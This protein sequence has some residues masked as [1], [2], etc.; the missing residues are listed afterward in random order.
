MSDLL[1][2]NA[3]FIDREIE[4]FRKVLDHRFKLHAQSHAVFEFEEIRPPR[5]PAKHV[6]YTDVVRAY[7]LTSAERL[8]L[9]LAYLPH[10]RPEEL[11]AFLVQNEAVNRRFT[12]FGGVVGTNHGGFLPTAETALYLLSGNDTRK[13][14]EYR[15]LFRTD[16]KLLRFNIL[17]LDQERREEPL[18]AS[19]LQLSPSFLELLSTG[20]VYIPP[21]SSE[22]PAQRITT[23]YEWK[24]LVVDDET[25]RSIDDIVSWVRHQ[26]VLMN[27]WNL[28][29]RIKPGFRTLFYGPPGT[30]KS[31]TAS[32]LG[33]ATK[34]PVFRVDLSKV[35]S[36]YIGETEKN[37]ASLFDRAE[38][39]NWILFFD[40]A[41]SVFG[42]RT[43]TR[44]SNDRSA[45]QQIAYLL[46][47]IEEFPG[48]VIL[49]SNLR[50]QIDEAF[51]R[52]FQSMIHFAMPP[53]E[54]RLRLW[55]DNFLN[56][57]Y[58][59]ARG[60]DLETLAQK[61]ELSGGSIVNVLRYSCLQAVARGSTEIL[62]E[63]ILYA[64]RSERHKETNFSG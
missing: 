45:N 14:L 1:A 48:V 40:E 46:Q 3:A 30:G 42:K 13:R 34:M 4:W 64:I 22:F 21:F 36:K 17:R 9:I 23:T 61:H 12:Q 51:A 33:K 58:R 62:G 59:L 2:L 11:D 15:S 35:F 18:P 7:E 47:R 10:V 50:S 24:D 55:Q 31:L 25:R 26:D 38:N 5:L 60:V 49:A 57:K 39:Q 28:A 63:D 29:S 41:D 27:D 53:E 16:A 44:N 52:R 32:L 6:P 56:K 54:Q 20:E 43:E 19:H 8:V 37:L